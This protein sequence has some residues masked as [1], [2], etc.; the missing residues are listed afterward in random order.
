MEAAIAGDAPLE[1]VLVGERAQHL[2]DRLV[3]G[4]GIAVTSEHLVEGRVAQLIRVKKV[5]HLSTT[6]PKIVS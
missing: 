1:E 4:P 5:T 2:V 6:Y 3:V